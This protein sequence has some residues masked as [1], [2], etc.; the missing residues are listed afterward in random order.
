MLLRFDSELNHF[1]AAIEC[2]TNKRELTRAHSSRPVLIAA[3]IV[4]RGMPKAADRLFG[5]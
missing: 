5:E 1:A 4:R 3:M 2:I